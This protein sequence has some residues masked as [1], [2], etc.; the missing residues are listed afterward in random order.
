MR[1]LLMLSV[2]LYMGMHSH[3]LVYPSGIL[4]YW[5]ISDTGIP[6][7]SIPHTVVPHDMGIHRHILGYP[8]IWEC[9]PLYWGTH[10][11]GNVSPYSGVPENMGIH[12][13]IYIYIYG[14]AVPHWGV[15]QYMGIPRVE[16]GEANPVDEPSTFH[17]V[18][19]IKP[20][21]TSGVMLVTM[22]DMLWCKSYGFGQ[23]LA[24]NKQLSHV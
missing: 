24:I 8:S 6:H 14:N 13:H 2:R 20:C 9:I 4:T 23:V 1:A 21:H 16:K 19:Q 12:S 17:E 18:R 5:V 3:I 22:A 11:R 7:C 10:T 15:S